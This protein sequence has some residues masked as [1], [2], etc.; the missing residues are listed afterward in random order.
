M[1]VGRGRKALGTYP[2]RKTA[3]R[4]VSPAAKAGQVAT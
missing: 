1:D 2:D 3:M 4:A